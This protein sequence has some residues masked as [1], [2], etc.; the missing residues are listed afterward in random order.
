MAN[1][2]LSPN[3]SLPVPVIGV[4]PGPQYASDVNGCLS[5]LDGH[6]HSVGSGVQITPAGLNINSDLSFL[7]NNAT[8]LRSVR[9]SPQLAVLSLPTDL[10]C[11]YEV[12]VDLYYNDGSGNNVRITQSGGVAGTP[13]SIAN[14]T[15]PA[16]ATY[17][18]GS[19]TFVWQSAASTP[20][21][22]DGASYI[23]RNLTAN[24]HGLTL[25][26]P[27]AM[28]ADYSIVLPSLPGSTLPVTIDSAGNMGSS[29]IATGQIADLAVTAAKIAANTITLNQLAIRGSASTVG[30]GG[31]AVSTSCGTFSTSS[32]SFVDVT[33]LVI[34]ITTLGGPVQIGLKSDESSNTSSIGVVGGTIAFVEF[35]RNGGT[36]LGPMLIQ[37]TN[38]STLLIPPSSIQIVDIPAAG[39]WT[40][41]LRIKVNNGADVA[42][43]FNAEIYAYEF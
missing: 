28:G 36:P 14:L 9:F 10:G 39:T 20:A 13:G 16:S 33:N 38:S 12:G 24:S 25:S 1:S 5:I 32:T 31:F 11:L 17:V 8:T 4:D 35:V 41:S 6:N 21:N 18:S 15:S 23:L 37:G 3:M 7:A 29:Q 43:C 26:P 34:T 2:I 27:N 19:Q 42:G 22:M 30:V 40:Y